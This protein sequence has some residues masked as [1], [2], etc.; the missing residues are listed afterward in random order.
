MDLPATPCT[1]S[2]CAGTRRCYYSY[3]HD[4]AIHVAI[5]MKRLILLSRVTQT[6]PHVTQ[7][8]PL[9]LWS[10]PPAREGDTH[11]LCF[12]RAKFSGLTARASSSPSSTTAHR[13]LASFQCEILPFLPLRCAA[14]GHMQAGADQDTGRDHAAIDGEERRL[15]TMWSGDWALGE[16]GK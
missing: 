13:S 2:R 16:I 14:P 11:S 3:R 8:L 15:G 12:R 5:A 9:A 7:T 1:P 10:T 6:L 4:H